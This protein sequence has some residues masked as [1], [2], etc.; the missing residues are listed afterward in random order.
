MKAYQE[1]RRSALPCS[2]LNAIVVDGFCFCNTYYFLSLIV[3]GLSFR[4]E[5]LPRRS[6]IYLCYNFAIALHR[7][8]IINLYSRVAINVQEHRRLWPLRIALFLAVLCGPSS[9]DTGPVLPRCPAGSRRT[10]QHRDLSTVTCDSSY[11][12][13]VAAALF[14]SAVGW[15]RG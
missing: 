8:V 7:N 3:W 12:W 14:G 1:P 11:R 6:K 13:Q 9:T 10:Q 5:Q 2:S 4:R 15:T